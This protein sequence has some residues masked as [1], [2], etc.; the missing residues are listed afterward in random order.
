MV[1]DSARKK[2]I[3]ERMSVT[4]ENYSTAARTIDKQPQVQ[5][6]AIAPRHE[7]ELLRIREG[8]QAAT[9]DAHRRLAQCPKRAAMS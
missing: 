5:H 3:R 9:E 7:A 4:G 8:G 2:T 1:S 6:G